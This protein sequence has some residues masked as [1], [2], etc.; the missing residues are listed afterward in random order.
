MLPPLQSHLSLWK[1]ERRWKVISKNIVWQQIILTLKYQVK[2]VGKILDFFYVF[3]THTWCVNEIF[4]FL[5]VILASYFFLSSPYYLFLEIIAWLFFHDPESL[6]ETGFS[7]Q[8]QLSKLKM[9][10][11]TCKLYLKTD[12]IK[13]NSGQKI[14]TF[15]LFKK[16]CV[17]ETYSFGEKFFS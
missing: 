4:I 12:P 10:K 2:R 7:Q 9:K 13:W 8:I 5:S 1:I 3:Y 16:L 6:W 15:H 17:F 14:F 11:M